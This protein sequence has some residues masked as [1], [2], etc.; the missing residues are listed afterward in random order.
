MATM[1]DPEFVEETKKLRLAVDPIPGE[2]LTQVIAE[3]YKTPKD[4]GKRVAETLG[5][6]SK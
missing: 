1:K 5:R 4:V 6:V 3:I 2:K